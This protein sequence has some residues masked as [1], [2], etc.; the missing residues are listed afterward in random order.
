MRFEVDR[1]R[2]RP[3]S[4]RLLIYLDSSTFGAVARK[5][6][7]ADELDGALR[8]AIDD[9]TGICVAAPWHEDEVALLNFGSTLDRVTRVI[10]RYTLDV[11]MRGSEALIGQELDAAASE[12]SGETHPIT[13]HEAFDCDPDDPPLKPFQADYLEHRDRP[14]LPVALVDEVNDMRNTSERLLEAH[15]ELRDRQFDWD[16]VAEANIEARVRYLLGPLADP[17]FSVVERTRRADLI[18]AWNQ[19]KDGA[20]PG[21]PTRRY[22]RFAQVAS[23]ARALL[24]RYPPVAADPSGFSWSDIVRYLPTI[25]LFSVLIAALSVDGKR[26]TPQPSDLHDIWHLT[27]GLSR[28]DIV[29]ADRRTARLAIERGLVPAGVRLLEAHRLSGIAAAVRCAAVHTND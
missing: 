14:E 22:A 7:G 5:D 11:Q 1:C 6:A 8:T 10:R 12:Y 24:E 9:E 23:N 27:Y 18:R 19:G 28:C 15:R 16:T 25:G 21:S 3:T 17:D 26:T 29:T 4:R 20:E 2:R 13:W